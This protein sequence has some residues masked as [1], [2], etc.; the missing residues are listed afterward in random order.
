M[1][2]KV[3][4][5][6]EQRMWLLSKKSD[7]MK[8]QLQ[9]TLKTFWT[10][11]T[12]KWFEKWPE[13]NERFL[14]ATHEALTADQ[15]KALG[16]FAET[17]KGQI[18]SWFYHAQRDE[19]KARETDFSKCITKIM[20][21]SLKGTRGPS[22]TEYFMC[23]EEFTKFREESKAQPL[24]DGMSNSEQLTKAQGVANLRQL[25]EVRLSMQN[26][27]FKV[28]ITNRAKDECQCRSEEAQ[29]ELVNPVHRK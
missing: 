15:Q 7:F 21:S 10:T 1:P 19:S 5:S 8:S 6:E 23:T 11:V 25:A 18:R 4:A 3:W 17:H 9:M 2:A 12:Y 28:E 22:A 20:K 14:G 24:G 27:E 29:A 26:E 16:K 13:I